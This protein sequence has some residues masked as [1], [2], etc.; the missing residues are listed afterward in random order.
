MRSIFSFV[1]GGEEVKAGTYFM[2][3][4][5][6]LKGI[7]EQITTADYGIESIKVTLPEGVNVFQAALILDEALPAINS[8]DFL[9]LAEKSEGYIYPDTYLF[10]PN[11][12]VDVVYEKL[13]NTFDEKTKQ[14]FTDAGIVDDPEAIYE[15]LKLASIIEEEAKNPK[16]RRLI[17]GVLQNRLEIGMALQVDVTFQYINGKN[18][19]E[20]TLGDLKDPSLYNTYVHR[21]LPPTP[22]SNPGLDSIDAALNPIENNFIYFLAGR[23]GTTYFSETFEEHVRKKRLYL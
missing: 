3:P 12:T 16:D 7:I 13:R 17:S 5:K 2:K 15:I 10:S 19:Y 21:G 9:T 22:I 11:D 20:L 1:S 6:T 8:A 14:L 23:D 18:T 4:E